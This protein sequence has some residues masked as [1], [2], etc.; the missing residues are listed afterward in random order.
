MMPFEVTLDSSEA[1]RSLGD[2]EPEKH[3]KPFADFL[4]IGAAGYSSRR[5]EKTVSNVHP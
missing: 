4:A 1:P 5:A 2:V 3:G